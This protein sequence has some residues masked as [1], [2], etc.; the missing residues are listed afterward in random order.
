MK[1]L[2]TITVAALVIAGAAAFSGPGAEAAR[3][4]RPVVTQRQHV[5]PFYWEGWRNWDGTWCTGLF[6]DSGA[7]YWYYCV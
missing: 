1:K 4:P 3:T 2:L 6:S 5:V 7:L